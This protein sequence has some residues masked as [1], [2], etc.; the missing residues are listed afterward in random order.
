[1]TETACSKSELEV[2]RPNEVQVALEEGRWQSYEPLNALSN[3]TNM[4]FI[5]PGTANEGVDMNNI[6]LYIRGKVT[7]ADGAGFDNTD[8]VQPVNNFLNSLFRNVDLSMNG[9]LLT[10]ATRDYAYKDTFLKMIRYDMPTHGKECTYAPLYG[11]YPD[12]PGKHET[13]DANKGGLERAK[14]I[15]ESKTFEF[16]GRPCIDLF[17]CDRLLIPGTDMQ[18]KFYLNDPSFFLVQTTAALS[19][20]IQIMEAEL[21]VRRVTIGDSFVKSINSDISKQEALYPFTRREIV[22]M[23]VATGMTTYVKENLFRG[24]L[25]VNYFVAMVHNEAYSGNLKKNPYNFQHFGVS[26]IALFENGQSMA[27]HPL[28][29]DFEENRMVNAY[30]YLLEANGAIGE[31]PAYPAISYEAFKQG[32][33]IFCF[34]RSPD[35]CFN[36][37]ALPHHTGNLNLRVNFKK[38]LTHPITIIV[39]AEFDSRIQI[40]ENKNVSTDYAV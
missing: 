13:M 16:R 27:H 17:D 9:Q 1:M 10:R 3:A 36:G 38:A 25:A 22:T 40:N 4:E 30:Q 26:E 21:Y 33:T 8:L 19:Y 20:K 6:T 14:W 29:V 37:A 11:Y 31:R 34:T 35:L 15:S 12:T 28:K 7:K 2:F 5:I 24:Q 18:L 32:S 39:M 23:S